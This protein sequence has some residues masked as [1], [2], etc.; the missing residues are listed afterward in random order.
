MYGDYNKKNPVALQNFASRLQRLA[1]VTDPIDT[2]GESLDVDCKELASKPE[3]D[4]DSSPNHRGSGSGTTSNV[5]H[6]SVQSIPPVL[7]P[8]SSQLSTGTNL[9]STITH[10]NGQSSSATSISQSGMRRQFF[11]LC[12]DTYGSERATYLDEI[13]ITKVQ[14]DAELFHKIY[15]SYKRLRGPR[16]R[17][18]LLRPTHVH[19]VR[20]SESIRC[21]TTFVAYS[22]KVRCT[23]ETPRMYSGIPLC[24]SSG[25]R[26]QSGTIPLLR[27]SA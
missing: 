6:N 2:S 13:D 23:E 4:T 10:S 12:V 19:F 14:N 5:N 21:P 9:S 25:A 15:E 27:M 16:L 26:S 18:L 3:Q 20:V 17:R 24:N 22:L 11:E 1:H 7:S 8:Q